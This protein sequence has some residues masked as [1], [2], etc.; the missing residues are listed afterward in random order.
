MTTL[1]LFF[2]FNHRILGTWE[3]PTKYPITGDYII[4]EDT[5][6]R[7][8]KILWI[9]QISIEIHLENA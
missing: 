4:M 3:N 2:V 1:T 9:D 5:E 7:V 8:K 6:Y